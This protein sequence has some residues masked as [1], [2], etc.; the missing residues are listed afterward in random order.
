M[1]SADAVHAIQRHWDDVNQ[2]EALSA[3]SIELTETRIIQQVSGTQ[4]WNPSHHN[5]EWVRAGGQP[6]IFMCTDFMQ[7]CFTRLIFEFIGDDGWL[8]KFRMEMRKMNR[9]GDVLTFGGSVVEK[10]LNEKDEGIVELDLWCSNEH[11]GVTTPTKATVIL[12]RR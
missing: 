10:F 4:D 1:T 11:E 2:G 8:S 9:P 5:R 3:F 6:D 7:A 12:P